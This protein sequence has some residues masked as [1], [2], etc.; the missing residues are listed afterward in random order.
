MPTLFEDA[1]GDEALYRLE[2]L[3]YDKALAAGR[4]EAS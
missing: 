4:L 1:G 3:F 2:E